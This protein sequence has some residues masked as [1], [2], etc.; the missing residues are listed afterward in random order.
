MENKNTMP[1]NSIED[2][3]W[4]YIR[5]L[6]RGHSILTSYNPKLIGVLQE[7]LKANFIKFKI[8]IRIDEDKKTLIK[9]EGKLTRNADREREINREETNEQSESFGGLVSE[10]TVGTYYGTPRSFMP[11]SWREDFVCGTEDHGQE[12]PEDPAFH[13]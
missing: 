6:E 2:M 13:P 3:A 9:P 12:T 11:F 7:T 5:S 4:S 8:D 1:E 10:I